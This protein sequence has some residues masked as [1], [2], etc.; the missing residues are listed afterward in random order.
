MLV[1]HQK[2]EGELGECVTK[3]DI[4]IKTCILPELLGKWY[5]K[6]KLTMQYSIMSSNPSEASADTSGC[7]EQKFCYC[8]SPEQGTM[9]ACEHEDCPIEWFHMDCLLITTVPKGKW[10]CPDC[11][12]F[13][14]RK[15]KG[16]IPSTSN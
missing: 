12:K 8:G 16:H 2:G 1:Y 15:R 6:S 9:I 10:Y 13:T 14:K 5:T 11:R 7:D 4:F 3:V